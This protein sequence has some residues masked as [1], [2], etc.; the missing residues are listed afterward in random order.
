MIIARP[1]D[2]PDM[3]YPVANEAD[4]RIGKGLSH[5]EVA[6]I[7]H[8]RTARSEADFTRQREVDAFQINL[9]FAGAPETPKHLDLGAVKPFHGVAGILECELVIRER[10]IKRRAWAGGREP[11]MAKEKLDLEPHSLFGRTGER[12]IHVAVRPLVSA[13]HVQSRG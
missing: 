10:N 6:E 5:I 11:V 2:T 13:S 3:Q 9:A 7:H 12:K 1:D 4:E 8:L